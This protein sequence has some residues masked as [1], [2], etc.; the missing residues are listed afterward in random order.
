MKVR[1][2]RRWY[3]AHL[4]YIPHGSD[5]SS[6]CAILRASTVSFISHMVQMKDTNKNKHVILLI[7]FI[8]HMV[9]MKVR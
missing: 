5:E 4:L 7:F 9:Q 2:L 3:K 8:S 1:L 6:L